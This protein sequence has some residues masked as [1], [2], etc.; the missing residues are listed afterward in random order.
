MFQSRDKDWALI[1]SLE[2]DCVTLRH[3]FKEYHHDKEPK[4]ELTFSK[5]TPFTRCIIK[6]F[7]FTL[8]LWHL[9]LTVSQP[10]QTNLDNVK[11]FFFYSDGFTK[12]SVQLIVVI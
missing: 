9:G 5:T 10:P 1:P 11:L 8:L 3:T 2:K 7:K 12:Y 4:E 6:P